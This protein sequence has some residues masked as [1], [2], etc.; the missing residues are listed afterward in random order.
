MH[1]TVAQI[2]MNRFVGNL[3]GLQ[4]QH[5][6]PGRLRVR[7]KEHLDITICHSCYVVWSGLSK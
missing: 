2:E 6:R 4:K 5:H 1:I 7:V 3:V